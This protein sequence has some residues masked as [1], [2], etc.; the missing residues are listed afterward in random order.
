MAI[1]D[2]TAVEISLITSMLFPTKI[3]REIT[4]PYLNWN[5]L[6]KNSNKSQVPR[7]LLRKNF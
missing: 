1:G 7:N 4:N 6:T 2:K 5:H 3:M